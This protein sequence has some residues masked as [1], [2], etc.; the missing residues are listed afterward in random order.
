M[1]P[2]PVSHS[3]RAATCRSSK[4]QLR[5]QHPGL[6]WSG[7]AATAYNVRNAAHARVLEQLAGLDKRLGSQSPSRRMWCRTDGRISTRSGTG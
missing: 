2:G 6:T 5:P 7:G 3:T 1:R 4:R